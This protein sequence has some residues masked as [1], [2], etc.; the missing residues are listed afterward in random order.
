MKPASLP[1]I[2]GDNWYTTGRTQRSCLRIIS[3]YTHVRSTRTTLVGF[4]TYRGSTARTIFLA[5]AC[6]VTNAARGTHGVP[7][8]SSCVPHPPCGGRVYRLRVWATAEIGIGSLPSRRRDSSAGRP[9]ALLPLAA[10]EPA[11]DERISDSRHGVLMR[12]FVLLSTS[13]P[14][15]PP[16]TS[17][18]SV[19]YNRFLGN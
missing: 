17:A 6:A 16:C 7:R 19:P 18:V 13:T 15:A 3:V 10:T 9:C 2:I 4:R 14:I 12:R 8:Q 11:R 5:P 1:K